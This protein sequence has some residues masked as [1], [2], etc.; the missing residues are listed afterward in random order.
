[1][2]ALADERFDGPL[3]MIA[4]QSQVGHCDLI[5]LSSGGR[6]PHGSLSSMKILF[7]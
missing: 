4:Q 3:L 6:I 5:S 7:F 1:M 2:S